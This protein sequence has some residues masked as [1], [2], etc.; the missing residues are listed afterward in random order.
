M[1]ALDLIMIGIAVYAGFAHF[2]NHSNLRVTSPP[3]GQFLILLGIF[4]I[5]ALFGIDLFTMHGL[6]LFI[7]TEDAMAAMTTLHLEYSW[8]VI[9]GSTAVIV[10][11]YVHS[12]RDA[13]ELARR[14][15]ELI[16]N[17]TQTEIAL[18][19]NWDRLRIIID[20]LPLG[21]NAKDLEGR[22]LVANKEYLQ[23]HGLSEDQII[24]KTNE[25]IFPE[26]VE[27]N[28]AARKQEAAVRAN[29]GVVFREQSKI[30]EDGKM[31]SLLVS[32][33][34]IL[35]KDEQVIAIGMTGV[36]VTELQDAQ[37][38]I[39]ISE[40]R[41]RGAI[42][43]LQEAFVLFDHEDRLVAMNDE[44][45]RINPDAR[46]IMNSGGTFEDLIRANVNRGMM[47]EAI[48]REEEFIRERL[49]EHRSPGPPILR[50]FSDGHWYNLKET[51]TPD[52]GVALTFSDITELK[53][54]EGNLQ[55]AVA[56]SEFANRTKT[57][58][59]AHMSHELRTPLNSVI[60][61]GEMLE[62]EIFGPLGHSKYQEYAEDIRV[63][64]NH[65]LKLI[66][67]ILDISKIESGE[68]DFTEESVDVGEVISFSI[69]M[70]TDRSEQAGLT[71]DLEV[72]RSL[73]R[74]RGDE[75]RL[76]Q[77]LLNLLSNAVKFTPKGGQVKI[78]AKVDDRN[79]MVW[80]IVD[81]GVGIAAEDLSRILKPF[82]QV[83]ENAAQSHEGT[84]LGLY[85]TNKLTELHGGA[86]TIE[87]EVGEGTIVTVRFPP[88]RTASG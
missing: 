56:E 26:N 64:G 86:L 63:S 31:H 53:R 4:G 82:E 71:V 38:A 61:F 35:N 54:I 23:R 32:K 85:L 21:F 68:L 40:E 17:Q 45:D 73:P 59:L 12:Q 55:G 47:V 20:N 27:S 33:F 3:L 7:P 51:R 65:L 13:S 42:E 24:G 83:R 66:N 41:L 14:Q 37:E 9:V 19:E 87:S 69:R 46:D 76:K 57:E 80:K 11:G 1:T 62:K 43:S 72:P 44:Y 67:E 74:I 18:T 10:V 75:V 25:E 5:S 16:T 52:G 28:R 49:E 8:I 60:G 50:Q 39:R 84:G 81:T 79:A 77:I 88:E 29:K 34:P 15:E 6:P 48:G 70:V 58:F 78:E 30:F 22:H 36:D 2:A